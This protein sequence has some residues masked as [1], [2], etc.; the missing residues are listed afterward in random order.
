MNAHIG[1]Q[2]WQHHRRRSPRAA[3]AATPAWLDPRAW[4]RPRPV[5]AGRR[6]RALVPLA[7]VLPDQAVRRGPRRAGRAAAAAP[8]GGQRPGPRPRGPPRTNLGQATQWRQPAD[9]SPQR[10]PHS[11]LTHLS[12]A[13]S[14]PSPSRR[15]ARGSLRHLRGTRI[16]D[17]ATE[18]SRGRSGFAR[19]VLGNVAADVHAHSRLVHQ[20][21]R[22]PA[23]QEMNA[24]CG[25]ADLRDGHRQ[26]GRI[27]GRPTRIQ[28][29]RCQKLNR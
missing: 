9:V 22:R 16:A 21:I 8:I 14:T 20:P 15:A 26:S 19:R 28:W 27:A 3:C 24:E 17:L 18:A 23:D 6:C 13:G 7:T 10:E 5:P 12:D 2:S 4:R 1:K 11:S 29:A 25:R